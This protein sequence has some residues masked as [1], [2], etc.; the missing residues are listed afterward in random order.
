MKILT[1]SKAL[2][3]SWLYYSADRIL[4]DCGEGA[5][6]ILGNKTFAIKRVFLSHGHA[7]HIAGLVSLINIRNNAMGDKEKDLTIYYPKGNYLISE[8]ITF[9][10][11]TNRHLNYDLEWVPLEAGERVELLS[12][13]MPRYIET[14]PTVHTHNEASLGYSIV[15]VRHRLPAKLANA[16][17]SEII[18][19]VREKGREA[20]NETYHQC[21]FSYGGD[22]VPIKPAYIAGTEVL[23]HD[24]TFLDEEDRKEYKHA[25]L[26]EAIATAR[27]AEVKKELICF[28]IS[29]RYKSKVREIAAAS[30]HYE[31]LGFKVTLVPPGRIFVID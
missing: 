5:S 27:A 10:E 8:M 30:G 21:L 31:G 12:G 19:L 26:A 13:Q 29:S 22:S 20:V 9:I 6:S 4:F 24:T 28:H 7:D 14:F 23:C 11:R 18:K 15:E 3:S 2:Y 1:Y 16:S 25:T 17:Q